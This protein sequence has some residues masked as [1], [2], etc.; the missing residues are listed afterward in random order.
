MTIAYIGLGS[1]LETPLE[2]IRRAIKTL[3]EHPSLKN[4]SVSNIYASKP[5]GPQ[6]QPDYVNAVACFE[7]DLTGIALLDLL[8]SIEQDHRRVR[9]RHWG[10]RTLDLDLLLYGN[11]QI[12]L[13]RLTVPH[14]FMLERGFV[15]QPLHDLAPD[16]LLANGT[17]V[18]E[19]LHQLD[20]SD[21]VIIT[22]E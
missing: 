10:P 7:T 12:D 14:P 3:I 2:Q 19:Q 11:E 5:V 15:I 16:M 6:D 13:P 22:E 1:N 18:T 21:L 8:Q 4:V 20:T 17:T 9:E